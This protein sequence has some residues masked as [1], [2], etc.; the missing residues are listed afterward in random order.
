MFR[1]VLKYADSGWENCLAVD[2]PGTK[3]GALLAG[4]DCAETDRLQ[5]FR[6]E[7]L[8]EGGR[9]LIHPA[10]GDLCLGIREESA[11]RGTMVEATRCDAALRSQQ[12]QFIPKTAK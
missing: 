4:V 12:F 3:P 2:R 11:V 1:F 6:L 8:P 7:R 5:T 9:Y 10:A